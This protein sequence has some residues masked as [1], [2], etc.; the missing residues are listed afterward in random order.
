MIYACSVKLANMNAQTFGERLAQAMQDE[1]LSQAD[2]ARAIGV[3][4][5]AIHQI[6]NGASKGLR[7]EHLILACRRLR[8]RPEWLALGEGPVRPVLYSQDD[9]EIIRTYQLLSPQQQAAVAAIVREI[10]TTYR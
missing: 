1:G 8:V 7:P 2:L 6:I 5:S 4:R 10:S 3:S 9:C